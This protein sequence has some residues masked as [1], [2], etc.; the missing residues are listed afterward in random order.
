VGD[1]RRGEGQ[2]EFH[3]CSRGRT[4]ESFC[5][6]NQL[7]SKLYFALDASEWSAA[8]ARVGPCPFGSGT[9]RRRR[10]RSCVRW[11][12]CDQAQ[13]RTREKTKKDSL[14]RPRPV[15]R[16]PVSR[17]A[18]VAHRPRPR[19]LSI[20]SSSVVNAKDRNKPE[21]PHRIIH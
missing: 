11:V 2:R 6:D 3:Q 8:G 9:C 14:I 20:R 5:P 7:S 21:K 17:P 16:A 13:A 1:V 12:G 10:R 19:P 18:E 15:R 4:H